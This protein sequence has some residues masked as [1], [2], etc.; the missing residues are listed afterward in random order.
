MRSLVY[1]IFCLVVTACVGSPCGN[2]VLS[3]TVSPDNKYVATVFKHDCGATTPFVRV[4]TIRAVGREFEGNDVD[5]YVFTMRGDHAI[6]TH[7]NSP[8]HLVIRRPEVASEIFKE[9]KSW[10]DVH[11]EAEPP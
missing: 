2:T 3:Q 11:I 9:L 7:W 4:V 8:K 5:E 6:S 10:K 1:L